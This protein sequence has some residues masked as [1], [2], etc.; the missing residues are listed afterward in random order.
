M[1]MKRTNYY[2]P[3]EMMKRLKKAA[4]VQGLPVSELIRRAI[5]A[6]LE[7]LEGK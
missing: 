6:Y 1:N 2:Y 3:V 4:Q 5:D 7:R